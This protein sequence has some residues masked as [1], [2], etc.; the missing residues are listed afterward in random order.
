MK[1]LNFWKSL[2]PNFAKSS[3]LEDC[4]MTKLVLATTVQ[5]S[6][7]GAMRL[8]GS[9]K[10]E[11]AQ[12]QQDWERYRRAVRGASGANTIVAI[13]K[14]IKN[15]ITTLDL[16]EELVERDYNE[17]VVSGGIS[18]YKASVLQ[19]LENIGFASDYALKYLNYALVVET[20]LIEKDDDSE[21]EIDSVTAHITPAELRF[22]SDRF[23]DFCTIMNVLTKP[24]N[25]IKTDLEKIPDVAISEDGDR[26][27]A[28]TIGASRLDPLQFGLIAA[29]SNPIYHVRMHIA[30]WQVGRVNAAKAEKDMLELRMLRMKRAQEG[31]NDPILQREI[32]HTQRRIDEARMFI[33]DKE[34]EYA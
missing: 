32:E 16:V 20:A 26:V 28:T 6:Y 15:M 10:F 18:Y 29:W 24:T 3:V 27:V 22:L 5:P 19:M 11:N 25:N 13:D 23:G 30:S 8:F 33:R 7:E 12:L 4:R 17:D 2:L 1:A 31:K 34:Q 14:A 21:E 9:R